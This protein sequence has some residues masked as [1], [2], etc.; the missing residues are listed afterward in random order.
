MTKS[1]KSYSEMLKHELLAAAQRLGLNN[2]SRLRKDE[3]IDL[4]KKAARRQARAAKAGQ[5]KTGKKSAVK[6]GAAKQ[7]A[8][9]QGAAKQ[10]AAKQGAAKQGAAKQGAVKQ[11]AA[12]QGAAKQGAAKQG[13]A[14]QGAVKQGAAKQGAVKQGAAKQGA[15]R[16]AGG[17]H[18]APAE[19]PETVPRPVSGQAGAQ[20]S[21]YFTAASYRPEELQGV[22]ENLQHLPQAY[23]VNRI[24]LMPRDPSWLCAYWNLTDEYKEAAR[25]AGGT[26]LAVRLY[27]VTDQDFD[28]S[29]A[30]IAYEH[31]VAD[32]SRSWYLPVPAADR[33]YLVEIG[34]R[35]EQEWFPLARSKRVR[36]PSDQPSVQ[37]DDRFATIAFDED[38]QASKGRLPE[39][40]DRRGHAQFPPQHEL[41]HTLIEDGDLRIVVGGGFFSPSGV[42][43]WP[44]FSHILLGGEAGIAG[45]QGHLP[46]SLGQVAGSLGQVAGSLGQVAGSEGHV[47]GSPGHPW[48]VLDARLGAGAT[49]FHPGIQGM[50]QPPVVLEDVNRPMLQASVELVISGQAFPNTDISIAGHAIPVGPDGAF[51]LRVSVP[52]GMRA[53]P[54]EARSRAT[55]KTRRLTL[56]FGRQF[57]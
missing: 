36:S 52:E 19:S 22:D 43:H 51:S 45:S 31:G 25:A 33:E 23:D 44:L 14:K 10:G 3:I 53:V 1:K 27:D 50:E 18:T 37:K 4:I 49:G 57:E 12:K 46:G 54:I 13:A 47:A 24:V 21:K 11:G 34:Y 42:P 30:Q 8:A 35:G 17:G 9:K 2:L 15:A 29:A 40:D 16:H 41:T 7:G 32:W 28:G 48:G 5:P 6:Q 56:R 39:I 38:L 20:A 55:Q 26:T